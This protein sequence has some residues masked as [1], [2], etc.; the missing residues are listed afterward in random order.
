M[1]IPKESLSGE[2]IRQTVEELLITHLKK[3]D[4]QG[5]KCEGRLVANILVAAAI[6]G[7]TIE[8]VCEDLTVGVE[9]N[10][11]RQYLKAQLKVSDLREQEA[12]MNQCL[13]E[14]LP[15]ALPRRR[16]EMAIDCHDE[17]FYGKLPGLRAYACRGEAK[18][19]TTHFYRVASLY[20][21]WRHVRFTLALTY[22]LPEEAL[23][24]VVQ[25]LLTRMTTLAF[26]P[27]VLYMDKGFCTGAL[28]RYLQQNHIPALVAC[29]IRGKKGG[30]RAL[31]K[32][33]RAYVTDYTFTDGPTVRLALMPA[34][35]PDKTGKRRIKWLAYVL[36]H[37]DWSAAT[38]YLRYRRRF[39]IESSYRQL[40]D[41]RARTT[42]RN[43]ALRFLLLALGFIL[44]N[45]WIYLRFAA[46]R[47]IERGPARWYP[48][49]FQL[50]RF[51]AFLRRALEH[52]YGT[53]DEIAVYSF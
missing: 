37:L 2:D 51:I 34:R 38:C 3:L 24:T 52:L 44:L 48:H 17:P 7:R 21:M 23:E 46:T 35:L 15:A 8:S 36:V 40:D 29:P 50:P 28:L 42:S 27:I 20:V 25:R 10:T 45:V 12:A 5:Y 13:S 6:H 4:K 26:Q 53:C 16:C 14:C 32:G 47:V 22:V 19:G 1:R 31:C 39:G 30:I 11:I 49:L 33:R 41:V 9:S 18:E 43:P